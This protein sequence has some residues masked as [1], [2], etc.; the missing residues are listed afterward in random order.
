MASLA[1]MLEE[2]KQKEKELVVGL[3]FNLDLSN[4][5]SCFYVCMYILNLV[6]KVESRNVHADLGDLSSQELLGPMTPPPE[7]KE[8]ERDLEQCQESHKKAVSKLIII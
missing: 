7:R 3:I 1:K 8:F 6:C 4:N 5:K 2:D